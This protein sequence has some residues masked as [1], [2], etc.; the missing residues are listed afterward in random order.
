VAICHPKQNHRSTPPSMPIR[1][2]YAF[3]LTH[4]I[5]QQMQDELT[6][7]AQFYKTKHQGHKLYWDHTLGTVTLNAKFA[8]GVKDLTMSLYQA[9]VLLLFNDAN[10]LSYRD[11]QLQ[12]HMMCETKPGSGELVPDELELKRT[13]QSLA[14]GRKKVLKKIPPGKDVNDMDVFKFNSEFTDPHAKVHINSIQMKDTVS[15]LSPSL[16]ERREDC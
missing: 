12:T 8:S 13:L 10:E 3:P 6:R 4:A 9:V 14:C 7:Y 15:L 11:I 2:S 1:H 5:T 16:Q